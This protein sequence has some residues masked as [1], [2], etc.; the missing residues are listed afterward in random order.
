VGI[1]KQ[2]AEIKLDGDIEEDRMEVMNIFPDL[3]G[4]T[5]NRQIALIDMMF[6][7]GAHRFRKFKKMITAIKVGDWERAS[8]EAIE[9]RWYVQVGGRAETIVNQLIG[10]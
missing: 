4:F 5:Q 3:Q 9:S 10:G 7:L 2:Y 1:K 8:I 6:N